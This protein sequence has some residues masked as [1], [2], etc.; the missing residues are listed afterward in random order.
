[1]WYS[2][3][4]DPPSTEEVVNGTKSFV[5]VLVAEGD[6]A[7][8]FLWRLCNFLLLWARR[9]EDVEQIETGESHRMPLRRL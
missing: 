8:T 9:G 2:Q 7:G 6:F 5:A 1:M 4:F 3:W